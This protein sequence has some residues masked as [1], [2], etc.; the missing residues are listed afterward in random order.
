MNSVLT[1]EGNSVSLDYLSLIE[2]IQLSIRTCEIVNF[3]LLWLIRYH[4]WFIYQRH[5][6][7]A[8]PENEDNEISV[9]CD[10]YT[11]ILYVELFYRIDSFLY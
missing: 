9:I 10:K 5:L 7:F 1:K 2:I 3:S 6:Y 8:Q 4:E 11:F